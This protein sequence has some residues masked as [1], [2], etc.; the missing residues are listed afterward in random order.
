M[1]FTLVIYRSWPE[2]KSNVTNVPIKNIIATGD[3]SQLEPINSLSNQFKYDYYSDHCIKQIVKYE[4][5]SKENKILK[6]HTDK[7]MSKQ[8]KSDIFNKKIPTIDTIN[9]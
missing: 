6:T 1:K 2:S 4:I 5:Y 7:H 8:I 3:T 9:K